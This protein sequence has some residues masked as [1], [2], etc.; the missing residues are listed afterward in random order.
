MPGRLP[1]KTKRGCCVG[2]LGDENQVRMGY[3]VMYI[4]RVKEIKS[5][6]V[7]LLDFKF[8]PGHGITTQNENTRSGGGWVVEWEFKFGITM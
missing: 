3:V 7:L 6:T 2:P 1:E 4:E 8:S 5:M